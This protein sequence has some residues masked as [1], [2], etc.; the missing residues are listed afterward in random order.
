MRY[1]ETSWV[2]SH[3]A[4][5]C[6]GIV[7]NRCIR[8]Q[9]NDTWLLPWSNSQSDHA[10]PWT[11]SAQHCP[12]LESEMFCPTLS[13][14]GYVIP[15]TTLP[16]RRSAHI[17]QTWRRSAQ[18]CP[19]LETFKGRSAQHFPTMGTFCPTLPYIGMF[20]H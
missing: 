18:H 14:L 4:F 19:T 2:Q 9:H 20:L 3:V 5:C 12:T 11:R 17:S 10:L 1:C 7:F 15:N 8:Q 13:Y 6:T 16:W